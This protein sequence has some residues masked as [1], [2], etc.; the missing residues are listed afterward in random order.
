M[1]SFIRIYHKDLKP[2]CDTDLTEKRD[3]EFYRGVGHD[4]IVSGLKCGNSI[5]DQI[6]YYKLYI[7]Q[8]QDTKLYNI[9]EVDKELYC[10]SILALWK[11]NIYSHDDP[12]D[13]I[14]IFNA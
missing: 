10:A 8:I 11:L 6:N 1:K 4:L 13:P 9:E 3:L 14:W 5:P 12:H 7:K 2:F